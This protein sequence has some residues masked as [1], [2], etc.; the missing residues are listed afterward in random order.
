[1]L[2]EALAEKVWQRVKSFFTETVTITED[3]DRYE[4]GLA[5]TWRAVGV[6]PRL[7]F[8]RYG[9]GGHFSPHTDGY[10][11][12]DYNKRS[13]Y[14]FLLYLNLCE[15]G[16][17]TRMFA[18]DHCRSQKFVVDEG[19]RYRWPEALFLDQAKVIPGEAL[20]FY[21]DVPHEGEP[22][23]PGCMKYIIRTD[24]FYERTPRELDTAADQEAFHLFREADLLEADGK[25]EEATKLYRKGLK[26]SPAMGTV[27]G[28]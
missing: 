2:D 6:N 11:I 12:V 9:E 23:G 27:F 22:V 19:G 21:Q 1:M 4:R 13:L 20:A 7:L 8:A 14:S 5:G 16:G 15:Q 3:Q 17:A 25:S 24:I 18:H 26:L 10:T 28:L